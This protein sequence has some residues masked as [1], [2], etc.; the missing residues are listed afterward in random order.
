M[1]THNPANMADVSADAR[2]RP[3]LPADF[4]PMTNECLQARLS[5]LDKPHRDDLTLWVLRH[6]YG[7]KSVDMAD[8]LDVHRTTITEQMKADDGDRVV[9]PYDPLGIPLPDDLRY[10][11][12]DIAAV[13]GDDSPLVGRIG[14]RDQSPSVTTDGGETATGRAD[15]DE[16][17]G[18]EVHLGRWSV[19]LSFPY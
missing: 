9:V 7:M 12:V 16:R 17:V 3:L 2:G 4:T 13:E 6:H 11:P 15:D 19:D 5:R 8:Y 18:V 14:F 10:D 1:A